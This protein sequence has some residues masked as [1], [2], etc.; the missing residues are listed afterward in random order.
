MLGL[1]RLPG[2]SQPEVVG[3]RSLVVTVEMLRVQGFRG[4]RAK[5]L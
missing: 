5:A 1:L 4:S 3:F 2:K